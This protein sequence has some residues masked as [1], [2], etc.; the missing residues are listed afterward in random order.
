MW[1][2]NGLRTQR[3]KNQSEVGTSWVSERPAGSPVVKSKAGEVDRHRRPIL[4]GGRGPLKKSRQGRDHP[5]WGS[6]VEGGP[7]PPA[8]TWEGRPWFFLPGMC[9]H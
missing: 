5:L 3:A 9:R 8:S 2:P 6:R 4:P 1:G 7:L